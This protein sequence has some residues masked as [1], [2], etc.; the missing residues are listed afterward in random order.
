MRRAC[1]VVRV[2]VCVLVR[3]PAINPTPVS[4]AAKI[5]IRVFTSAPHPLQLPQPSFPTF[6]IQTSVTFADL[7]N[8]VLCV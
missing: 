5:S 2:R 3:H 8:I 1:I 7:K 4:T 6:T